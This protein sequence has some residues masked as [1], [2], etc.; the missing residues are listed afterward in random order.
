M[1]TSLRPLFPIV[2][3]NLVYQLSSRG[4]AKGANPF[5]ALVAAVAIHNRSLAC[6]TRPQTTES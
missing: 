4:A 3:S 1:G 5:A 2:G 6:G